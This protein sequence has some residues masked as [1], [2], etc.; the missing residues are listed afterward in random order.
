MK[1]FLICPVRNV[2]KK[3]AARIKEYVKDLEDEGHVVH[4]PQRDTDQNDPVGLRICRDNCT[5][6]K[7]ADAV[8]VWYNKDS[9]GSIFDLGMAFALDKRIAL[10]NR[11]SVQRTPHKSF[12]NVLLRLDATQKWKAQRG[13]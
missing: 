2:S 7:E 4:W 12:R 6:I 3:E 9:Q 13:Y 1:I 10:A 11:E 8:H 5:A